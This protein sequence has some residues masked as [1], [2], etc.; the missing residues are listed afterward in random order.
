MLVQDVQDSVHRSVWLRPKAH[1][2]ASDPQM[3]PCYTWDLKGFDPVRLPSIPGNLP[4]ALIEG[5]REEAQVRVV[6]IAGI[7]NN[8][9]ALTNCG[10]VLK[11][12]MLHDEN[13]YARGQWQYVSDHRLP[14][15]GLN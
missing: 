4:G 13:E 7:D 10:H 3:I 12:D 15:L 2:S 6:K 8:I 14:P 5:R 9:I 1:I 11:Y